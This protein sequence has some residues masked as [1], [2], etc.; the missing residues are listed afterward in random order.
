MKR[1][2]RCCSKMKL[3]RTLFYCF[4]LGTNWIVWYC[5]SCQRY[6]I[7]GFGMDIHA[8]GNR[9]EVMNHV[10]FDHE[11]GCW[12]VIE[13]DTKGNVYANN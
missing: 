6:Y 3:E 10:Q 13:G 12:I 11:K 9:L 8:Y 5:K 1:V 2:I 7:K 4:H